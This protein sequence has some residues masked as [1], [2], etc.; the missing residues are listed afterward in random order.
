MEVYL[1]YKVDHGNSI[2]QGRI[3]V[4]QLFEEFIDNVYWLIA[5]GG[6]PLVIFAYGG[7]CLEH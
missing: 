6:V 1:Q 5:Y 2:E 4:I 3:R 7:I